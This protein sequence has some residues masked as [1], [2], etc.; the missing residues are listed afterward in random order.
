MTTVDGR[1]PLRSELAALVD[2]DPDLLD[3]SVRLVDAGLDSLTM[4]RLL[5]W[6]DTRG[7]RLELPEPDRQLTVGDVLGLLQQVATPG[8]SIRLAGDGATVHSGPASLPAAAGPAADPMAPV[9]RTAVFELTSVLPGDLQFLHDLA[10]AEQTSFRW[11]YRG[12]PPPLERFAENLWQQVLVQYVARRRDDG[13]PVGHLIAYGAEPGMRFA[14]VGAAFRPEYAGT[15]LAAQAVAVFIRSLFHVFP[16]R[17]L[18]LQIPGYN[19]AQ[20]SSGQDGL[21]QVEGVLR[22]HLYYAGRTWDEYT[23]AVY[24]DQFSEEAPMT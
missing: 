2:L 18:Y 4:M 11:R 16:L 9:L 20:L 23:C 19:W 24:A 8:V 13:E 17:K 1:T 22:D 3:D 7:V 12:A 21:F 14:Y 5:T 15:G 10:T 6:L